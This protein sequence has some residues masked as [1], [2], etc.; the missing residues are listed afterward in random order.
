MSLWLTIGAAVLCATSW[1]PRDV[2]QFWVEPDSPAVF[3]FDANIQENAE[4]APEKGVD[5][6]KFVV[7]TTDGQTFA[8]G[9]GVLD[10]RSLR[11]ETVLPQGF[12]ELELPE[13][14][15]AFGVASQPAFCPFDATLASDAAKRSDLRERDPFFAID[16]ASTWLVN[17]QTNAREDLIR[18]A[19]RFGLATYRERVNWRGIEPT[20]GAFDFNGDRDAEKLRETAKKY[21]M[22]VLELFHNAPDWT[23]RIGAYPVDLLKTANSWGTVGERWNKYWNSIE[24]WNEP[25]ISFSGNLP[26]DQYAPVLKTVAQELRRRNIETP[27]VGGIIAFFQADYM[28]NLA[29][30]GVLDACD[31]FSFHTYCRAFEM[32]NVCLRYHDWLVENKAEWKP[33]WLTECGRPWKKGTDR[34]NREAD[35]ESA[36]DIVEKGVAAKALGVDSYFPFVYVYYE[37]NDNNFG[38]SDKNNAPLRSSAAYARSIYLLSGKKCF[39]SWN[40]GE[41]ADVERSYL[42]GDNATGERV[43]VLY[44]RDRKPGR[45]I[46]LP[47]APSFVERATGE[48]LAVDASNVVDFSDGFLFVGLPKEFEPALKEASPVDKARNLRF[49]ARVKHGADSRRNFST[50]ARFDYD[51]KTIQAVT[52]GYRLVD[53]NVATFEGKLSVYNFDAEPKNA[54]VKVS[55]TIDVDGEI[56]DASDIIQACASSIELPARGRA[57]LPFTLDVTK[58]SPFAVPKLRFE[59]GDDC[60]LVFALSKTLTSDNYEQF[61]KDKIKVDLTDLSRWSKNSS[62]SGKIELK[63][64]NETWTLDVNFSGDG[65]RWA[66]P[67]FPLPESIDLTGYKGVAFRIKATSDNPESVVRFFTYRR[68]EQG[69][70]SNYY[71]TGD[72]SNKA[73]GE[74]RLIVLPLKSLTAYSG[75]PYPF[76]PKEIAFVSIGCNSKGDHC[77]IEVKD[78]TFFK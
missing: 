27:V 46:Q 75:A 41:N 39:G 12:F 48:R 38:M 44:Q 34:P 62:P 32:E 8:E 57:E 16:A 31:I 5:S 20:E 9:V 1:T 72:D 50:V 19:R 64:E 49:A 43:A 11:V 42:F 28:T 17:S 15:Q 13:T 35:L 40:L 6:V 7:K 56:R 70:A 51:E 69:A 78:L 55:A 59:I 25:D 73:N 2:S 24:V 53:S 58:I 22:P 77:L 60:V 52:S 63:A 66:Y 54:T 3:W 14:G 67:V 71:F 76:D 45:T 23:G 33:L 36:I 18:N 30:N 37:E 68:N 4:N 21:D 61:A 26:G 47:C 29:E 74:E 65:D 10:G